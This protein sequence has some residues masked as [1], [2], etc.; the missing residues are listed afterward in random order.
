MSLTVYTAVYQYFDE[1][2]GEGEGIID[3]T[4]GI[5]L[6]AASINIQFYY[7]VYHE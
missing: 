6:I 2:K 3:I 1:E 5:L 4:E 7:F